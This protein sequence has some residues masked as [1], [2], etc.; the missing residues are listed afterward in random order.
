MLSYG[1]MTQS[2]KKFSI[3]DIETTGGHR[4][5]NKITEIAIINVDGKEIVDEFSTLID[6]EIRI[7]YHITALTGITNEMVQGAPKFY[8]IAKKI[9]ELT[10]GRIFVAHNVFFDFNFIKHEFSELGYIF[11]RP[12]LCT[13]QLSKKYLPGHNSYSLG[14]ICEDLKIENKSR[15]RA[16]GDAL[17]TYELFKLILDKVNTD[18][19]LIQDSRKLAIPPSLNRVDFE[20]LPNQ[21]G[22]YY[23]YDSQGILLYIGKSNDIKKRVAQHFHPDLKT[24]RDLQ[25]KT[26]VAKIN[27]VILHDELAALLYECH[28][29]KKHFPRFNY[30]LKRKRFPYILKLVNDQSGTLRINRSHN[31]G[32]SNAFF[33]VKNKNVAESKID[34]I[35]QN[36]IGTFKTSIERDS[37]IELL[38]KSVGMNHYNEML[39]KIFHQ[40]LPKQADFLVKLKQGTLKVEGGEPIEL[41]IEDSHMG[42]VIYTLESDPDMTAIMYNY[43]HK[44]SRPIFTAT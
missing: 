33:A 44:H 1:Q 24:K 11:S 8:E 3:I 4:N 18:E 20:N 5:G 37:K 9:V 22:V 31:D 6:P 36:L 40:R 14:K 32:S 21:T 43:L 29:I 13:V 7:P 17:A 38:V 34:R 26:L 19:E 42:P 35:Y 39:T 41:T 15:H 25:L 28:E 27:Y 30:S 10:E 16:M 23:F 12:K 2:H